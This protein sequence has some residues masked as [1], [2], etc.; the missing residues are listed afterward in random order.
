MGIWEVGEEGREREEGR[1][2]G[3]E[4]GIHVQSVNIKCTNAANEVRVN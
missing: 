3:G 2:E 1:R 4:E